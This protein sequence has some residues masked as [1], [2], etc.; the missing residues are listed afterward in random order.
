[1]RRFAVGEVPYVL[2]PNADGLF[3]LL[4][5]YYFHDIMD[6]IGKS[7]S[8]SLNVLCV[9]MSCVPIMPSCV[10][11]VESGTAELI[12]WEILTRIHA[13]NVMIV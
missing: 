7:T 1:M 13:L 6:G 5:D 3:R 2:R 9:E 10:K 12:R 4:G 11:D 8:V